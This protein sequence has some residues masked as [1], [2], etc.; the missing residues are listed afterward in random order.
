MFTTRNNSTSVDSA[1]DI[2]SFL[3]FQS[4]LYTK[5]YVSSAHYSVGSFFALGTFSNRK[6]P[7]TCT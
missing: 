7:D 1:R 2:Y 5:I 6:G 4:A 3:R